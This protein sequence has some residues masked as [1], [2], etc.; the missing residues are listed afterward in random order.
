MSVVHHHQHHHRISKFRGLKVALLLTAIGM[1]IEF[2][3]GILSNSLALISDAW[4][5]L[6]HLFALGMSYLAMV[7][8]TRPITKKR[9]YGFYRA[10]VLAAFVNGIVLILI[11]FYIVYDAFR[12]FADPQPVNVGEMLLVAMIGFVINGASI[13]LLFKSGQQDL[14]IKSAILHEL[15]DLVSSIA[16]VGGGIAI[17]YTKEYII[18]PILAVMI[19]A[20]IVIWSYRLIADSANILL[21]ATP[22]HL[23]IDEAVAVLK[24]EVPGVIDVNHVHAWTIASSMYSLT[25]NVVVNDCTVS[26]SQEI[27]KKINEL[28]KD[29]FSIEHTNIQFVCNV[30]KEEA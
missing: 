28:L 12:R 20:L 29:R 18:D 14:N 26:R 5:M 23:D 21:E 10:E 9:T 15:G 3:G 25:A 8:A 17:F 1:L 19:C 7:L 11:A 27:L 4:H 16:V 22:A 13:A 24:N 6:T 30:K 2:A